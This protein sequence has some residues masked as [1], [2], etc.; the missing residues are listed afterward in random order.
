M[1]RDIWTALEGL[2]SPQGESRWICAGISR[3]ALQREVAAIRER[4]GRIVDGCSSFTN[5]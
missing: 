1:P 5:C 4:T 2:D 3:A